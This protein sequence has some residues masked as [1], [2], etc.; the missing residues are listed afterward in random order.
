[1]IEHVPDDLAMARECSRVMRPGARAF[2]GSVVKGQGAWYFYRNAG[3]WRLDPTH[4]REYADTATY[5]AILE[6]AG[7]VVRELELQ[8]IAFPLNE[9]AL[10]LLMRLRILDARRAQGSRMSRLLHILGRIAIPI[11]RYA[12]AYAILEKS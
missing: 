6:T 5:R 11:P 9:L 2:I 10:R 8:P 7:F 1:M 4:V 12:F 3:Y